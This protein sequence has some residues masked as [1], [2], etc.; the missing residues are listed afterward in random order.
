MTY[1][2]LGKRGDLS[3]LHRIIIFIK[4]LVMTVIVIVTKITIIITKIDLV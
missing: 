1:L 2:T 3:L 4:E